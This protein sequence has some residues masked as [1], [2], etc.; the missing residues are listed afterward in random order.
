MPTRA[1]GAEGAA[2]AE[3][4]FGA[5]GAEGAE[6]AHGAEGA[7]GAEGEVLAGLSLVL[8]LRFTLLVLVLVG[9]ERRVPREASPQP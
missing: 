5:E 4:A 6:G 8:V 7:C 9:E 1:F 2:T 3:G